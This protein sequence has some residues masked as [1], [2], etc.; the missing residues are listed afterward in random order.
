MANLASR[1]PKASWPMIA[2]LVRSI[3]EQADRDA[4]WSQLGEVVD[5]LTA[6]GFC[7][8]ALYVLDAA[9]DILAFSA[10][11]V[12]HWPKIR[13]NN[14]QERL[15]KEIRRRTDVVG[16]F[17]NR[18]AVIRLVGA[19]LV[20]Q[21]DE[22]IVGKRYMGAETLAAPR[23]ISPSAADPRPSIEAASA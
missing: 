9:D 12:E 7:D 23:T 6:A 5:K 16:I 3:F 11:P 19:L 20:E 4:T 15:N 18:H 1:V 22:W 2:T 10:F 8:A 21:N 14:P 13:S 17:P